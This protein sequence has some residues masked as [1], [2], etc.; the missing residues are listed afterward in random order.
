MKTYSLEPEMLGVIL[1]SLL[2]VVLQEHAIGNLEQQLEDAKDGRS[3][4]RYAYQCSGCENWYES[5]EQPDE[6]LAVC[7]LCPLTEEEFE[8]LI[9]SL[10]E[11]KSQ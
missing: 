2:I 9:E 11:E 4:V 5:A 6:P 3:Y 7:P 8:D 10:R 1:F